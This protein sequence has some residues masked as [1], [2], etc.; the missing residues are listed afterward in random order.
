MKNLLNTVV[1]VGDVWFGVSLFSS[2]TSHVLL[3]NTWLFFPGLVG[4]EFS[5]G[6]R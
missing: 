5:K 6:S 1:I 4:L 3:L 2:A